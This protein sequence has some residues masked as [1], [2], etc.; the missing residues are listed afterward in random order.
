[1]ISQFLVTPTGQIAGAGVPPL[2]G[3]PAIYEFGATGTTISSPQIVPLQAVPA[4]LVNVTLGSQACAIKVY[5]KNISVAVLPSGGIP[6]IPPVYEDQNPVLLDLFVNDVLVIGGVLCLNQNLIV[7][8]SYLG[9]VG[10]L[11]FIDTQ[12]N[13]DPQISGIGSRWLLTYWP[14]I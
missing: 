6:T 11:A 12:G 1:V 14:L 3:V 2:V 4:Q 13:D 7:R 10:D 5:G 8:D 9:F